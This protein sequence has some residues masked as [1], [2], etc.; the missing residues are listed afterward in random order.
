MK[1][2]YL[3]IIYLRVSVYFYTSSVVINLEYTL[4]YHCCNTVLQ[5]EFFLIDVRLYY[6]MVNVSCIPEIDMP[7]TVYLYGIK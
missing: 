1:P 6:G 2:I 3:S 5:H 4:I 7:V